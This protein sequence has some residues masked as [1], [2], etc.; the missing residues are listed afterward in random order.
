MK[1]ASNGKLALLNFLVEVGE[2]HLYQP[3]YPVPPKSA[4]G[5]GGGDQIF[6]FLVVNFSV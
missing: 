5:L 2:A 1:N 3:K 6:P 4:A